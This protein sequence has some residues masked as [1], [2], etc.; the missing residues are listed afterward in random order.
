[1]VAIS[2]NMMQRKSDFQGLLRVRR[3]S[4]LGLIFHNPFNHS[5]VQDFLLNFQGH[6]EILLEFFFAWSWEFLLPFSTTVLYCLGFSPQFSGP[7]KLL[8][9]KILAWSRETLHHGRDVGRSENLGDR[10]CIIDIRPKPKF[11][12]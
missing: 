9:R 5:K 10:S 11:T 7:R 3:G 2:I 8:C 6:V 12:F 4:S 1:M